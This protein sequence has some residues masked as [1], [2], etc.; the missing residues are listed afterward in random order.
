MAFQIEKITKSDLWIFSKFWKLWKTS[1]GFQ[2]FR[3]SNVENFDYNEFE[4]LPLDFA[5]LVMLQVHGELEYLEATV[6]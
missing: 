5:T 6:R 4:S 3:S 2:N 1:E